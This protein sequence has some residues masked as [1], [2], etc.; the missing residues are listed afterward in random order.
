MEAGLSERTA[1][2]YAQVVRRFILFH[3]KQHRPQRAAVPQR[4]PGPLSVERP[5]RAPLPAR[6]DSSTASGASTGRGRIAGARPL[7]A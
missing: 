2:T 6:G 1:S 7:P 4:R 3:H 5:N